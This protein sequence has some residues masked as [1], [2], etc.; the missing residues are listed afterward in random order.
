M[1]VI[2]ILIFLPLLLLFQPNLNYSPND[3][4]TSFPFLNVEDSNR[5]KFNGNV[6]KVSFSNNRK[7]KDAPFEIINK[8]GESVKIK[9]LKATLL[10]G[11][12]EEELK[13][14]EFSVFINGSMQKCSAFTLKT[15]SIQFS[16]IFIP[17]TIYAGSNYAVKAY[18]TIDGINFESIS[19][20]EIYRLTI[21]DK[22]VFK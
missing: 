2:Y 11:N 20:L 7:I 15:N 21:K 6:K 14:S 12:T 22:N 3:V 19:P 4:Q 1:P 8:T 9:L 10:R 5:I 18:I 16:I 17:Y 13:N